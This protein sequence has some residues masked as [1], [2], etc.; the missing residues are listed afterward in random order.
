[1]RKRLKRALAIVLCLVSV[2]TSSSS[3][4]AADLSN[5]NSQQESCKHTNVAHIKAKKPSCEKDGNIECWMCRDC[6]KFFKDAALE[7]EISKE[8][9]FID[10]GHRNVSHVKAKEATCDRPGNIE[11][12][13]CSDC[14][15]FFKDEALTTEIS[16][17]VFINETGHQ[18][19]SHVKAKEATCDR[20]GNIECWY[21]S[22]CKKF[23]KDEALT[24]E[25]SKKEVFINETGHQ[26]VSHVKAKEATCDRPG[27]IECWYC[28]DCKFF[29]DEALTTEISKKEVFI[30]ETGHQDVSSHVKAKEATCDRPGNIECWYCS[31]CKEVLQGRSTYNRD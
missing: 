18:D 10:A 26:D 28:S 27:N 23:F 8:E 6:K 3:V 19:V 12:W 14:K 17:E 20:P 24:T 9:A 29:K 21:C 2:F 22:D 16:K 15:K 5:A 7:N 30:N 1:M 25:I 13:Y 4:L 31:D 11:C